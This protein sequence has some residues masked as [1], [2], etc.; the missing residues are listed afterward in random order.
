MKRV[1][2]NSS[3]LSAGKGVDGSLSALVGTEGVVVDFNGKYQMVLLD[4]GQTYPFEPSELIE[5]RN[6][7]TRNTR[8]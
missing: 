2:V 5:V 1:K 3:I 7:T 4:T 6:G 8:I